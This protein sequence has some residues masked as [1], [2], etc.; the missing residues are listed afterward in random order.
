MKQL[1]WSPAFTRQLK[2][3]VRQNLQLK[4]LVAKKLQQL[5]TTY[6]RSFSFQFAYL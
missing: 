5:T 2:R 3:L 4:N 6:R 1:I